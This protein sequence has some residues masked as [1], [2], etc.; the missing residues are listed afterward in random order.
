MCIKYI[1]DVQCFIDCN[2]CTAEKLLKLHELE[3][4]AANLFLGR[5]VGAPP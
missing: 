1:Y 3:L 5:H 2:V 4:S